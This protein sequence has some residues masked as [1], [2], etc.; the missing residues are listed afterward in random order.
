MW[1]SDARKLKVPGP[2]QALPGRAE[3]MPVPAKH[4]VLGTPLAPPFPRRDARRQFGMGCFWGAEKKF[5]QPPG[6][7]STQVGYA[8]GV[9]PNP[10]YREVCSGRHRAHRG[11]ARGV[12]P[13]EGRPTKSSSASSGRATTRRR[14]CVR[15]T[16][17]AP[18]TD[19]ASTST[20]TRSSEAAEASRDGVPGAAHEGRARRRSRR[21]SRRA[22][23]STTP[24]T[25]ISSTWP[26]TPTATAA[27]AA[28][29]CRAR[30]AH[31]G[32]GRMRGRGREWRRGIATALHRRQRAAKRWKRRTKTKVT[33]TPRRVTFRS[34]ARPRE[35]TR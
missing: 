8:G 22:P 17:W 34:P 11:R 13:G 3:K 26:R 6:V 14:G 18:S 24:R 1:F 9:T 10:T 27:S 2:S 5:W 29:A 35:T 25:T 12:R 7:Y 32:R 33:K 28:R 30:S 20:A 19:R 4:A 23:S 21:R 15:A 31:Q 16:T